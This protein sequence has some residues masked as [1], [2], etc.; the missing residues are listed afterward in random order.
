MSSRHLQ[1]SLL[2]DF[3]HLS[4]SLEVSPPGLPSRLKFDISPPGG[5]KD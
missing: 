4:E 3:E 2:E 1:L 5:M